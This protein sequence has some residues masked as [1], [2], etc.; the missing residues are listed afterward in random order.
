M[1]RA[2]RPLM[3]GDEGSHDEEKHVRD[4]QKQREREER[5]DQSRSPRSLR[6]LIRSSGRWC[7]ASVPIPSRSS[8]AL[9]SFGE[10]RRPRW[11]AYTPVSQSGRRLAAGG[12]LQRARQERLLS[13]FPIPAAS[14][15]ALPAH[16][17]SSLAE[18]PALAACLTWPAKQSNAPSSLPSLAGVK[19]GDGSM[20]QQLDGGPLEVQR[21]FWSDLQFSPDC[22]LNTPAFGG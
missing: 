9:V 17:H 16:F 1:K 22:G 14:V 13:F 15:G 18:I 7:A 2:R 10:L 12:L 4:M 5:A 21:D 20:F 6:L 3:E 11:A 19:G 8:L